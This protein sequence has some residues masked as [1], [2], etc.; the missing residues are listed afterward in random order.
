MY[1]YVIV[2]AGTAGCVLAARLSEDPSTRVLLVEAGGKDS[3]QEIA[4]PAAFSKLFDTDFDWG[5]RTV[6]QAGLDDR[7]LYWPRGRVLGGSSSINAMMWVRGVPADYDAWASA[8]NEGWSY[9]DVVGFFKRAEDSER[10]DVE[11]TGSGGPVP[12]RDQR[13][14]N[15]GTHLFVEACIRA[16]LARNRNANAGT[17]EGVDYTQ[18]NQDRGRR[19][20]MA[21]AYLKPAIK[22]PNLTVVTGAHVTRV[23]IEGGRAVGVVYV[24]DGEVAEAR[25]EAEVILSGGAVNS[26]HILLLS[27][28]GPPDQLRA[29]GVDPVV[30]LPGVG[31]NLIDHLATGIVRGTSRT[32]TLVAAETPRQLAGYLLKRRGLLTSNVGEAHA[33]FRSRDELEDPDLELVFAPVPYLDHGATVPAGHGYTIGV[34]LLQPMSSG[35]VTLASANPFAHPRIDPA[36]LSDPG[37]LDVLRVGL[38][39]AFEVFETPPLSDVVTGWVRPESAF[40]DSDAAGVVRRHAETLYHPAGTCRM[41]GDEYAVVDATLR[42]HGVDGLRVVDASVM[43]TLNRGHTMAPVVMIAEKAAEMIRS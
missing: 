36:Y 37:D 15:P 25:V 11:H 27:G 39:K 30:D 10:L 29:A 31:A 41:G 24:R 42:V 28:V 1:D 34:V 9:Q 3:K 33:F 26:P 18:V 35:T 6:P 20:S 38:A 8:G 2:G 22:R 19:M 12:I 13:D 23:V 4:V 7:T 14:V 40:E 5:Y 17:N 16:G 21:A 32:D 43:P